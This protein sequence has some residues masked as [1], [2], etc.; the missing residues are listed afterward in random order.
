MWEYKIDP[1][2]EP[3]EP[4]CRNC[5]DIKDRLFDAQKHLKEVLNQLYSKKDLNKISLEN[6]LD[7]LCYYLDIDTVK[8]DLMIERFQEIEPLPQYIFDKLGHVYYI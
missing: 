5:E 7:E 8:G 3:D 4:D 6:A 2:C 1:P